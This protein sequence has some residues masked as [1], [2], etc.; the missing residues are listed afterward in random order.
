MSRSKPS[1]R[2]ERGWR[3]F[4]ICVMGFA[5]LS[6]VVGAIA[7]VV[8]YH[9]LTT[10]GIQTVAIVDNVWRVKGGWNCSVDFADTGGVRRVETV[11]DCGGVRR[12]Q[13]LEVT[14]DRSHPSTVDPTSSVT[15]RNELILVAVAVV[16]SVLLSFATWIVWRGRRGKP[17]VRTLL[18]SAAAAR[19]ERTAVPPAGAARPAR[20]GDKAR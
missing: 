4:A 12:G 13:T 14:Y 1:S 7:T 5:A 19:R 8:E 20:R 9:A 3:W 18:R 16:C 11:S 2:V 17:S 10:R 15:A 6:G